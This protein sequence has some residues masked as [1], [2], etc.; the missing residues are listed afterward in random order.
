LLL[1]VSDILSGVSEGDKVLYDSP[2]FVLLPDMKSDLSKPSTVYLLA[3]ARDES[4]RSMRDLRKAHIPMLRAIQHEATRIVR[5]RCGLP[6]PG[7]L[8]FFIHYQP[9]Y[10]RKHLYHAHSQSHSLPSV[11]LVDHFHVHIAHVS[12]KSFMGVVVG[13]AHLLDDVINLVS[14]LIACLVLILKFYVPSCNWI[15]MKT[16]QLWNGSLSLT[17]LANFMAYT[18]FFVRREHM[19]L[20]DLI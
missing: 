19:K 17:V 18:D 10:C 15:Q 13:Q 1:R 16:I 7:S 3:I 2:Q 20:D 12:Q 11:F 5:E 9:S 14:S 4:I 6:D 8:R